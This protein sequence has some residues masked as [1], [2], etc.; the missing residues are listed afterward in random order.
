MT[1]E[2][3]VLNRM[4]VALA[5]DSAVT[6]GDSKIYNT[7]NK[8]FTLSKHHPVGIMIFGNAQYMGIPWETVIKLY[9]EGLGRKK[10]GTLQ[11]YTRNF[12]RFLAREFRVSGDVERQRIV[13]IWWAYFRELSDRIRSVLLDRAK[14]STLDQADVNRL[15]LAVIQGHVAA[16]RA[17]ETLPQYRNIRPRS[18]WKRFRHEF[19]GVTASAFAGRHL[20]AVSVKNLQQYAGLILVKSEFSLSTSGLVFAGFGDDDLF[21]SICPVVCSGK[22]LGRLKVREDPRQTVTANADA[23]AFIGAFAQKEMVYRFMEGIDPEYSDYL[24]AGI[25]TLMGSLSDRLI[26]K[27]HGSAAQ[28]ARRAAQAR[29]VVNKM[30][31]DF[32][33]R[34][35]NAR[36]DYFVRPIL[37]IVGAL[38]KDELAEL[39]WSLVN[40]TSLK[41]KISMDAETVGGPIDVAVISKGDGFIWIRRKH[42]FKPELNPSFL[43][44]YLELDSKRRRNE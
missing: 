36:H 14:K 12:L 15:V 35:S 7:V 20:T 43:Q 19:D 17:R 11:A 26:A 4:A 29:R 2:V 22:L 27:S 10:F 41:R 3:V 23:D 40:I 6:I 37:N 1:A 24:R 44:K 30:V 39:A 9:R 28:R 31:D 16:L 42:Y 38:P 5:A 32:E 21:P 13:Q 25:G 33:K 8:L 34:A 18:I